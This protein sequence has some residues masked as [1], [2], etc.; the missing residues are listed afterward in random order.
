MPPWCGRFAA[1]AG[2]AADFTFMDAPIV[3]TSY[4]NRNA[5]VPAT[6]GAFGDIGFNCIVVKAKIQQVIVER[7]FLT[8]TV[9][10][11]NALLDWL[12]SLVGAFNYDDTIACATR[13]QVEPPTTALHDAMIA[14]LR[15]RLGANQT[16]IG[17]LDA[18][19]IVSHGD[20]EVIME[21]KATLPEVAE[22]ESQDNCPSPRPPPSPPSSLLLVVAVGL[23]AL[24]LWLLMLRSWVLL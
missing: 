16:S 4:V 24:S 9:A 13:E 5:L 18:Y 19:A 14:S 15:K 6:M 12:D 20:G 7:N 1:Q 17:G 3:R 23:C 22:V 2:A 21:A 8:I 11:T 10:G